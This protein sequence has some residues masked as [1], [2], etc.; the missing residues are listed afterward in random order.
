M[1]MKKKILWML[2]FMY[3]V[4]SLQAQIGVNTNYPRGVFHIDAGGDNPQD[5]TTALT[6]TQAAN[7]V[8]IDSSTGNMGIGTVNPNAKLHI[9]APSGTNGF[10][11]KDGSEGDRKVLTCQDNTGLASWQLGTQVTQVLGDDPTGIKVYFYGGGTPAQP[12]YKG[13]SITIPKG[14][15]ILRY[16]LTWSLNIAPAGTLYIDAFLSTSSTSMNVVPGSWTIKPLSAGQR[17]SSSQISIIR[18]V[19]AVSETLYLWAYYNGTDLGVGGEI[20]AYN[21]APQSNVLEAIKW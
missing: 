15:W 6:A 9:V 1:T 16:N 3:I 8:Y 12:I 2:C 19:T 10:I 20:T 14:I 21:P 17:Y 7:D 11:L 5:L 4:S 18:E 13:K